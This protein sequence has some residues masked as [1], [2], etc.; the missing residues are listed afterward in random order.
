MKCSVGSAVLAI[1]LLGACS[2]TSSAPQGAG[3]VVPGAPAAP[4]EVADTAAPTGGAPAAGDLC[5]A[6]PDL[7]AIEA[8][9][10]IPVKDP[11]GI[12]E[13]GFQQSCTLLRGTDDFPGITF[14]YTPGATMAGQIEFV[15]T[16]FGIDIVPLEGAEGFYAGE[17]NSVY[18]E[19]NGALYQ[20][21]A[22][23][24]GDSRAAS[25]NMLKAWLAL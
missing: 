2:T 23:I 13:A 20:A 19:G 17:G 9:I 18:W 25:L 7:A 3:T 5:T 16:N 10:G 22:T 6:I 24:D 4:G 1:G 14:T 12:G 8:A 21:S 11:L 15:K